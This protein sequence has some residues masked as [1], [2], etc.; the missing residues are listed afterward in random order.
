[1]GT[2]VL[3]PLSGGGDVCSTDASLTTEALCIAKKYQ[4]ATLPISAC[5]FTSTKFG[6][7]WDASESDCNQPT[8]GEAEA[9]YGS[10]STVTGTCSSHG[11][12][13]LCHSNTYTVSDQGT[14]HIAAEHDYIGG[15]QCGDKT[16][17]S[18]CQSANY[19]YIMKDCAVSCNVRHS[20]RKET[21]SAADISEP[22]KGTVCSN[23]GLCDTQA[24]LCQCFDG[25]AGEACSHQTVFF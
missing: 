16:T 5:T 12:E 23:R 15:E 3:V 10:G 19:N 25:Y 2:D 7:V 18:A 11:T 21:D 13:K 22:L 14:C 17:A 9:L 1:M 20:S 4:K 6:C 8:D 24:G